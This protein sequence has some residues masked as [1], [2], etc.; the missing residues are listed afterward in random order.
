MEITCLCWN[1][2]DCSQSRKIW[3]F[4]TILSNYENL[5]FRKTCSRRLEEN[6][7]AFWNKQASAS[8]VNVLV[9]SRN[10]R[11]F[12]HLGSTKK[13]YLF[14]SK[15]RSL[16]ALKTT[17]PQSFEYLVDDNFD[18]LVVQLMLSLIDQSSQIHL[19]QRHNDVSSIEKRR[20][21][22]IFKIDFFVEN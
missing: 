10:T 6:K 5:N 1:V 7:S 4:Q 20:L 9:L 13:H 22:S 11:E 16:T 18:L 14:I 8:K 15:N 21:D 2:L 12:F 19:H 17:Y 3:A